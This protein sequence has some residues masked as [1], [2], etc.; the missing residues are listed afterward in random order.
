MPQIDP[1]RSEFGALR[2]I[3]SCEACR[4]PCLHMPG[5]LIPSDLDRLRRAQGVHAAATLEEDLAWC[6]VSLRASPGALAIREG[7]TFRI[8][9]L[10]PATRDDGACAFLMDGIGCGIQDDSPFGCAFFARCRTGLESA[11]ECGLAED[12]LRAVMREWARDDVEESRYCVIWTVLAGEGLVAEAPEIR[13]ARMVR[14]G[15]K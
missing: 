15:P 8:P 1:S 11:M 12:G 14:S 13:R 9:T 10:V 5:F 6:R 4:E 7:R 3:C 2:V